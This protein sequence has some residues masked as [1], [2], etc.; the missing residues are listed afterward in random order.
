M[1][2]GR[3]TFRNLP[4]VWLGKGDAAAHL[5][6]LIEEAQAAWIDALARMRDCPLHYAACRPVISVIRCVL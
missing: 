3:L 6:D 4:P 1:T 2:N 5:P